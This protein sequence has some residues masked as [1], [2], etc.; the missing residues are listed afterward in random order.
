M[1]SHT[2]A[3]C[4]ANLW[5]SPSAPELPADPVAAHYACHGLSELVFQHRPPRHER[6]LA[7]PL[8]QRVA[9]TRGID[10]PGQPT[11]DASAVARLDMGLAELVPELAGDPQQLAPLQQRQHA[12]LQPCAAIA[13][14]FGKALLDQPLPTCGKGAANLPP[15]PRI[16]RDDR[17]V[18]GE[19]ASQVGPSI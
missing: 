7:A 4:L 6:E 2:P 1:P 5:S 13:P 12:A 17:L 10:P 3:S 18:A 8:D 9:S 14:G 16:A 11:L 15:E 19:R